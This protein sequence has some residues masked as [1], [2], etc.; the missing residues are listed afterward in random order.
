[1][2]KAVSHKATDCSYRLCTS[3]V[4]VNPCVA[5]TAIGVTDMRGVGVLGA[6]VLVSVINR[7]RVGPAVTVGRRVD[8]GLRVAEGGGDSE[9]FDIPVHSGAAEGIGVCGT[10][11]AR[12]PQKMNTKR[13]SEKYKLT[14]MKV[15]Y[16]KGCN[17]RSR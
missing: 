16:L 7:V 3:S 2:V 9:G 13:S 14:F 17:L 5:V 12:H 15:F 4:G 10:V 6:G 11:G 1:M 8:V